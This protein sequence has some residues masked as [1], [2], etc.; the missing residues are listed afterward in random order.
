MEHST[1]TLDIS[2]DEES[3]ARERD[4]RGKENVPPPDDISQTRTQISSSVEAAEESM[5]DVKARVR[6]SRRRKADEGAIEIDRCPL[7][8]LVAEDFYAEGLDP[9]QFFL[10]PSEESSE[11][12]PEVEQ[13]QQIEIPAA[14]TF[15]CVAEVK[16]KG[17][18]EMDVDILMAKDDFLVAPTAAK[19]EP[20]EGAGESFEVW[21]SESAK[22]DE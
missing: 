14:S 20:I 19:L 15:D 1:C 8:D 12:V 9:S 21:E 3:R 4:N 17:R 16:G 11:E 10:I 6:A 22:G 2:S 18:L 7:G 5:L 13:Q